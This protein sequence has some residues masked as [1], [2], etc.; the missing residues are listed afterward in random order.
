MI[1]GPDGYRF[2]VL[3]RKPE[4]E[5]RFWYV[6]LRVANLRK[7]TD[8]YEGALGMHDLSAD[9]AEATGFTGAPSGEGARVVGYNSEEVPLLLLEDGAMQAVRVDYEGRN[10]VAVPGRALRAVYKKILLDGCGGRVLHELREF[11]EMPKMR[12]QRGLPPMPC[13]PSPAVALQELR[14]NPTS[15]PSAG[16]LAVAIVT[17]S[18]GYEICLV[19]RETYDLAVAK[20]YNP[21]RG[22]DWA[23]RG[24]ALAGRRTPTPAHML[25]C[26]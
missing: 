5:E 25:A 14:A 20:A 15:A 22:I 4:R 13:E 21:D 1:T 2:R 9:F 19:S 17:D 7:A 11:N 10:A 24:E 6:A 8:F 16:T 3:P 12:Q 18:D 26:V 23:W